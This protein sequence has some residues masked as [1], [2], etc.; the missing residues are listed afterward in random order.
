MRYIYLLCLLLL[1]VVTIAQEASLPWFTDANIINSTHTDKPTGALPE[2]PGAI[3]NGVLLSSSMG[4]D[5][6]LL[7]QQHGMISFWIKP[8]WNGNDGLSH[9]LLWVG[10]PASNGLLIEKTARGTLRFVMASA[11]KST[12]AFGDVS[13]WEAGKWHHIVASWIERNSKPFGLAL[14][15]DKV[16]VASTIYGGDAFMNPVTMA[17]KKVYIGDTTSDAVMDELIF[18]GDNQASYGPSQLALVYRDYFRTAPFTAIQIDYEP[19]LVRAEKRVVNGAKKQFGL[20][21]QM[22]GKWIRIT[23]FAIRYSNWGEFDAKP[24]ISWS[25][26]NSSIATVDNYGYN[27]RVTGNGLG[28]CT[29]TANFRGMTDTYNLDVISPNQPDIDVMYVER[30]PRY[31]KYDAKKWPAV[32]DY[33]KS[34]VHIGNFGYANT[35]SDGINVKFELIPDTNGNFVCDPDELPSVTQNYTLDQSLLPGQTTTIT[36]NWRW[37]AVPTFV[38]VTAD[39]T[40][41]IAEI[42]EANNQRC[43]LNVARAFHWGYNTQKF[44]DD[45]S[46]KQINLVGSFSDYDWC[47]SETDR[48]ARVLREAVYPTTSPYGIKDSIR[49]DNFQARLYGN[50]EDEPWEKDTYLYDGGFPDME[51]QN[52]TLM[53]IDAAIGHEIGHTTIG[54]PDLYGFPYMTYNVFLKDETGQPYAGNKLY[55]EVWSPDI[56]PLTS[57]Y[58]DYPDSLGVGYSALMVD[59]HL[60][61]DAFCAGFSNRYAQTRKGLA[62]TDRDPGFIIPSENR[63]QVF[64]INS[65]PLN[66]AAVYVYPVVNTGLA[67]STPKYI[68]DRPKY[69]GNTDSNGYYVFPKTT[70]PSWDDPDTDNVDG[71]VSL[72]N[73]FRHVTSEAWSSSWTNGECLVLKIV[74]GNQTEFQWLPLTEA[75]KAYMSGQTSG[76]IYPIHTSLTTTGITPIVRPI[77]PDAIKVTNR[78]PVAVVP[79]EVYVLTGHTITL[80][81]SKSYD[82]E[83]Q[84]LYY[85]WL[86]PVFSTQPTLTITAPWSAGDYEY[87]FYVN[88]GLR[89]SDLAIVTVKVRDTLPPDPKS[90]HGIVLNSN[91]IAMSGAIVG[92]KKSSNATADADSYAVTDAT[93]AYTFFPPPAPGTYYLAA[94]E[95]GW[96][97]TTDVPINVRQDVGVE[98]NLRFDR[99]AGANVVY[100]SP[101]AAATDSTGRRPTGALDGDTYS[102]GWCT[103][104]NPTDPVYYYIDL[105][106]P[107][108]ISDIVLYRHLWNNSA[109]STGA[110]DLQIDVMTE[111][112]PLLGTSWLNNPTVRTA[113]SAVQSTHG[114]V[115]WN[116]GVDPIRLSLTGIKGIRLTLRNT[117]IA[118]YEITEIQVHDVANKP[119]V[120]LTG[121][122]LDTNGYY[123]SAAMVGVKTSPQATAD[124]TGYVEANGTF[125]VSGYP[126]T[127][128]YIAAWR[129]GYRPSEDIVVT[130]PESNATIPDIRLSNAPALVSINSRVAASSSNATTSPS[131][132]VD[133]NL[134]TGWCSGESA[135]EP[136]YYYIDLGKPTDVQYMVIN[137]YLKNIETASTCDDYQV[138]VISSGTPL[139]PASWQDN[140]T[141]RTIYSAS[142]TLHGIQGYGSPDIAASAI[143]LPTLLGAGITGIRLSFKNTLLKPAQ[144]E[145][146]DVQVFVAPPVVTIT[147]TA[148]AKKAMSGTEVVIKGKQLTYLPG[149]LIPGTVAYIEEPDRSCGMRLDLSALTNWTGK[150]GDMVDVTGSIVGVSDELYVAVKAISPVASADPIK[151]VWMTTRSLGGGDL[152][153]Q[154][155]V[156]GWSLQ[157]NTSGNYVN[158]LIKVRGTSNI[159]LLVKVCGKV[160]QI[161]PAGTYFYIDD[162]ARLNDGTKTGTEANIGVRVGMDGR[163]YTRGQLLTITGISSCYKETDAR[164]RRILRVIKIEP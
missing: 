93:G 60:W 141:M 108:D 70:D 9:K 118:K 1:P 157:K 100:Y 16:A 58:F 31:S 103:G 44:S 126:G 128:Y 42:C 73:P 132:A 124:A 30:T 32:G 38:R 72:W 139:D 28:Q 98:Q 33:V 145:L 21:A 95:S 4:L 46:T 61:L 69:I 29:L 99:L 41:S 22:E 43:E 20:M 63:L 120:V 48:M 78:K 19:N 116:V 89:M 105:R 142:K 136:V 11:T 106:K 91:G 137:R 62:E 153:F 25:T 162:G 64:D 147:R 144:Y 85:R 112:D 150:L 114:Y 71:A 96:T 110:D 104:D 83:G 53:D 123:L 164:L 160:T 36:F 107:T 146:R 12:A 102:T 154:Y 129:T 23:D 45:Y 8:N 52:G 7:N 65:E 84:P 90:I 163:T 109:G 51:P 76:A 39:P 134:T 101:T 74:S 18:R 97:P 37:T 159:G 135:S 111:G 24:F 6:P 113:Y 50:W 87:Q 75:N 143:S 151:P 10:N 119:L 54:L 55:P 68:P 59:C 2:V 148:D 117:N 156:W 56:A 15:I 14:W 3:G 40:N 57:A 81:G 82:P 34:I 80:D 77:I 5:N 35:S 88:D 161:D 152:G 125:R 149:G 155:G 86:D 66:G 79:A 122:V 26:S 133:N 121:R 140:P 13:G 115:N 158:T 130:I 49:V 47:T 27:G 67:N 92:L 94:W 138:D 131:N 17:D 127:T